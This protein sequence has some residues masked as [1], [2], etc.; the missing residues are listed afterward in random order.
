MMIKQEYLDGLA[1]ASDGGTGGGGEELCYYPEAVLPMNIK[2]R[3]AILF[4]K[5]K[6]WSMDSIRPYLVNVAI[7]PLTV[8]KILFKH[9]R[10]YTDSSSGTKVKMYNKR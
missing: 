4:E 6:A 3:M 1:L 9:A 2:K 10:A 5:Q 7:A 8:E